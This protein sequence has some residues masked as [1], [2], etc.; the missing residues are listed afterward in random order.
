MKVHVSDVS[1]YHLFPNTSREVFL[2]R[3]S[4]WSCY[5][6]WST[7]CPG[8][9][10]LKVMPL[11]YNHTST[12]PIEVSTANCWKVHQLYLTWRVLRDDMQSGKVHRRFG[13]TYCLRLQPR[14]Q[15]KARSTLFDP[16]NIETLLSPEKLVNFYQITWCHIPIC[17]NSSYSTLWEFQMQHDI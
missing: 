9:K 15:Q 16:D 5:L 11:L 17:S 12:Q 7:H 4:Y 1:R 13:G 2:W 14:N 6:P 8:A 3:P 10:G